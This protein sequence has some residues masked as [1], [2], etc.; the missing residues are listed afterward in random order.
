MR[1]EK[2]PF[3]KQVRK[4]RTNH[5]HQSQDTL[6]ISSTYM[7]VRKVQRHFLKL[8]CAPAVRPAAAPAGEA[9]EE[10]LASPQLYPP[11]KELEL[12]QV[13][14]RVS[15]LPRDYLAAMVG[16]IDVG[17]IENCNMRIAIQTQRNPKH[18][19]LSGKIENCNMI[20]TM[21]P[22]DPLGEEMLQLQ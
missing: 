7:Q 8:V 12:L 14:E 15:K 3:V 19:L 13:E 5:T 6:L 2:D 11:P 9:G 20:V 18:S 10:E 21:N 1:M 4:A 17:K 16:S 22:T